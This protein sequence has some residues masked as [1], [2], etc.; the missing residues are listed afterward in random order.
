M[1]KALSPMSTAKDKYC[2]GLFRH[3]TQT[4]HLPLNMT[5][6]SYLLLEQ[7]DLLL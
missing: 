6:K 3:F 5:L 1:D 7:V 4:L 2:S